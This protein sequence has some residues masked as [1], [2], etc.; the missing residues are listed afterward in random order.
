MS[1]TMN[2]DNHLGLRAFYKGT[3]LQAPVINRLCQSFHE[4]VVKDGEA[5]IVSFLREGH[6][7]S[8]V[9]DILKGQMDLMEDGL[10][11]TQK[12]SE[13]WKEGDQDAWMAKATAGTE[14]EGSGEMN[15]ILWFMNIAALLKLGVIANDDDNG[16]L[17]S[18][19]A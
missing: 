6:T 3:S 17:M 2:I 14:M 5:M 13:V 9:K 19:L 12:A 7:L 18:R 1:S 15:V 16:W 8:Q 11:R 10:C 4:R